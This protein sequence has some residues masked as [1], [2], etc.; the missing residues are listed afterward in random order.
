MTETDATFEASLDELGVSVTRTA[1]S[2]VGA[3]LDEAVREPAVGVAPE[4]E[5][6]ETSL[7]FTEAG[8]ELDPTPAALDEARTGVS[9]ADLGVADYGSLVLTQTDRGS[10]LVT[11]FVEHHVVLVHEADIAPDMDT[12]VETLEATLNRTRGA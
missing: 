9:T 8:V 6:T 11:L 7:P 4:D 12:A 5:F 10:E 1:A 3:A 2:E